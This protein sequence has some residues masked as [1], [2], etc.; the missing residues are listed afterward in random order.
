MPTA[1]T[2]GDVYLPYE[3]RTGEPSIVYFTREISPE[4]IMRAYEKVNQNITG[5]VAIKLH[6]G[7][8]HGPNFTPASWVKE[9]V[10]GEGLGDAR[11]VE[12][13]TYYYGHRYS[14]PDHRET[15]KTNG[16]DILG[17]V[18]IMDADDHVAD[19]P[20]VG[21]KWCDKIS[22]GAHM[23]D[24]D[25]L[26]VLTHFKGH[27]AGGFGGANKNIGIGC[28]SGHVGK[29]W[30]HAGDTGQM[31]GYGQ[32]TFMERMTEST[33]GTI[34]HFGDN[35]AYVSLMRNMSVDC[36][37]AGVDAAPVVTPNVG[38]LSSHDI[39]AIDTA[40]VDIVWAMPEEQ[41]HDLVE[42]ITSRHGLR[43]LTYMQELGMGSMRYTLL[44]LDNGLDEISA[45]DAAKDLKPFEG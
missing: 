7:E 43:Q 42:R 41:H 23:L 26:I 2:G 18:D 6:T 31:W 34:D 35:I 8:P 44:D 14:T 27:A 45:A 20:V 32:E 25:S 19:L 24:Y 21:G 9:F 12:T 33:K 4:G 30:I 13:N 3:D 36:D 28:A 40:C 17:E 11:I 16:W 29:Q 37:C 1:A 22:V 15:L 39:C 5:K 10:D 38:I